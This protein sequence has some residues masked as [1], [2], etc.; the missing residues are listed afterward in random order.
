MKSFELKVATMSNGLKFD[1]RE[2]LNDILRL[3]PQGM[4]LVEMEKAL[5]VIGA[6]KRASGTVQLEDDEH[7]YLL[8]RVNEHRW[9]VADQAILDFS[10]EVREAKAPLEVRAAEVDA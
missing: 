8:A 5:R 4:D 9:S 1:Y 6:V 7:Q 3:K 2:V 10:K